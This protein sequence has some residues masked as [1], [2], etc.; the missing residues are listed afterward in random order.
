MHTCKDMGPFDKQA[1]TVV[2]LQVFQLPRSCIMESSFNN[3]SKS[4]GC[5]QNLIFINDHFTM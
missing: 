2:D 1:T 4:A 3:S 5:F